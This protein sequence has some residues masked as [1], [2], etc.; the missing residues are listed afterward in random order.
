LIVWIKKLSKIVEEIPVAV[1]RD[2]FRD[3]SAEEIVKKGASGFE[4]M[5]KLNKRGIENFITSVANLKNCYED[6]NSVFKFLTEKEKEICEAMWKMSFFDIAEMIKESQP[7]CR[8]PIVIALSSSEGGVGKS[9]VAINLAYVL[10][11]KGIKTLVIDGNDDYDFKFTDHEIQDSIEWICAENAVGELSATDDR[12]SFMDNNFRGYDIVIEDMPSVYNANKGIMIR[13]GVTMFLGLV[14]PTKIS[15][16]KC[17]ESIRQGL[18]SAY[19]N[20]QKW[21]YAWVGCEQYY[22]NLLPI[23]WEKERWD[24]VK[25]S[26]EYK[27]DGLES[28]IPFYEDCFERFDCE[29]VIPAAKYED[30]YCDYEKLAAELLERY[31]NYNCIDAELIDYEEL[32]KSLMEK[33]AHCDTGE[34]KNDAQDVV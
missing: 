34:E 14:T 20:H 27:R 10:K 3:L 13:A 30:V 29:N 24:Q 25:D 17:K 15:L 19:W 23:K 26:E 33:Y 1:L 2:L 8:R 12:L 11:R 6:E 22:F 18:Y 7:S 21:A 4:G 32:G 28:V 9:S 16:N 5:Y 31:E